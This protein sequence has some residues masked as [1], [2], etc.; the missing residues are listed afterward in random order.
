MITRQFNAS[1]ENVNPSQLIEDNVGGQY[2]D[3]SLTLA[4][5]Y[6]RRRKVAK[7]ARKKARRDIRRRRILEQF[8]DNPSVHQTTWKEDDPISDDDADSDYGGAFEPPAAFAFEDDF[9]ERRKLKRMNELEARARAE[10]E[11]MAGEPFAEVFAMFPNNK[12]GIQ[13]DHLATVIEEGLRGEESSNP[14][15][16]DE[17]DYDQEGDEQDI[18]YDEFD[19]SADSDEDESEDESEE[20]IAYGGHDRGDSEAEDDDDHEDEADARPAKRLKLSDDP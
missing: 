20:D 11:K 19:D 16:S 8:K 15:T 1:P 9:S 17:D 14:Y 18:D 3:V 2:H 6:C 13:E 7:D 5:T 10:S 4:R 12:Y